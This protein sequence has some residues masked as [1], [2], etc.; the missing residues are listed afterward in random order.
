ME[1]CQ[2][3]PRVR[4]RT[5]CIP[6]AKGLS[7]SSTDLTSDTKHV[8]DTH[9]LTRLG[10]TKAGREHQLP[11]CDDDGGGLGTGGDEGDDEEEDEER[12]EGVAGAVALPRQ[13][14]AVLVQ[15]GFN[16]DQL[17]L[18]DLAA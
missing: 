4:S 12:D 10:E 8:N 15:V 11:E 14:V 2:N 18:V 1:T 7:C 16:D 17:E 13:G 3:V 9:V 5:N 6:R